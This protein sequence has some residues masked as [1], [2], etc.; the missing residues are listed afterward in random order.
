MR[1]D[2]RALLWRQ[3]PGLQEHLRP[4]LDLA[5]VMERR[6]GAKR[7]DALAIPAEAQR[8]RFRE[9]RDAGTVTKLAVALFER[10]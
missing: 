6:C 5:D 7:L 10:A 4:N 3:W 8:N 1:L 2:L 9:S